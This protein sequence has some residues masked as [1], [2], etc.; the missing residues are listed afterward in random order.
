MNPSG[1]LAADEKVTN[2]GLV[3]EVGEADM[4]TCGDWFGGGG[5]VPAPRVLARM[6]PSFVEEPGADNMY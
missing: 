3:P 4:L 5:A 1:S 6:T 2:S